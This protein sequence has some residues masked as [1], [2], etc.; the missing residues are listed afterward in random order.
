MTSTCSI[1]FEEC[2][3]PTTLP[4]GH[5][6]HANCLVPW[7]WKSSSCPNCRFTENEEPDNT[8]IRVVID[9]IRRQRLEEQRIFTNNIRES[10]NKR[11][12]NDLKRIVQSYK[13]CFDKI[14]TMKGEINSMSRNV[15]R[16]IEDMNK[17][18]KDLYVKYLNEYK[19][20]KKKQHDE[21]R[22]DRIMISKSKRKLQISESRLN[23]LRERII[24]FQE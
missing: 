13:Q 1:C 20:V 2:N 7:L 15:S 17:E 4:C 6:F 9:G 12:S 16:G 5:N 23:D 11:A 19:M 21:T 8:S 22:N 14:K 3:E 18:L 24:R 10:R